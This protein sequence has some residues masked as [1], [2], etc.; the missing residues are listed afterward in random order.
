[1]H[2]R[3]EALLSCPEEDPVSGQGG[4]KV[5]FSHLLWMSAGSAIG[6]LSGLP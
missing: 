1:M 3:T 4:A 2:L 5:H 6:L